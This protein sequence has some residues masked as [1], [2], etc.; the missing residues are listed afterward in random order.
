MGPQ[1]GT[2]STSW[3]AWYGLP[4]QSQAGVIMAKVEQEAPRRFSGYS[5]VTQAD[6]DPHTPGL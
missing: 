2:L 3:A 5:S 4:C 1:G 6:G